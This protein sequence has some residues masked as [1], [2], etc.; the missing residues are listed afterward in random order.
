MSEGSRAEQDGENIHIQMDAVAKK[1]EDNEQKRSPQACVLDSE[2]EAY[3]SRNAKN[4]SGK[5][6]LEDKMSSHCLKMAFTEADIAAK[7][8]ELEQMRE[9]THKRQIE[10]LDAKIQ[11]MEEKKAEVERQGRQKLHE[12]FVQRQGLENE[13][14]QKLE[15]QEEDIMKFKQSQAD[16]IAGY[17]EKLAN[18][19]KNLVDE[20][21]G[22][23]HKQGLIAELV[24]LK[25]DEEHQH[26][27]DQETLKKLIEEEEASLQRMKQAH[28]ELK[29]K[30]KMES[31]LRMQAFNREKESLVNKIAKVKEGSENKTQ[32]FQAKH[33]N[34][35]ATRDQLQKDLDAE[36]NERDN[37]LKPLRKQKQDLS[38][39]ILSMQD[40]IRNARAKEEQ[41]TENII[42]QYEERYS[43]T[44]QDFDK[45]REEEIKRIFEKECNLKDEELELDKLRGDNEQKLKEIEREMNQKLKDMTSEI[46][47]QEENNRK[48]LQ[49][50][51]DKEKFRELEEQIHH[52]TC[53]LQN[54]EANQQAEE[55]LLK[56]WLEAV[57]DKERYLREELAAKVARYSNKISTLDN[58]LSAAK[59]Q[60]ENEQ[61]QHDALK[62]ETERKL[63]EKRD[64]F[65][66][67]TRDAA[68]HLNDLNNQIA[69][70]KRS[71]KIREDAAKDRGE[72]IERRI[73]EET[74]RL[75]K[76]KSDLEEQLGPLRERHNDLKQKVS[77]EKE[78]HQKNLEVLQKEQSKQNHDQED[79]LNR[80][81]AL[82]E[83]VRDQFKDERQQLQSA[84][85]E[86]LDSNDRLRE[87][88]EKEIFDLNMKLVQ[89]LQ[90]TSEQGIDATT[91][92]DLQNKVKELEEEYDRKSKSYN[93][94]LNRMSQEKDETNQ[95][96]D[97]EI[98]KMKEE[99][100]K[101]S[102]EYM[103]DGTKN[104][105]E[106]VEKLREMLENKTR[107][108]EKAKASTFSRTVNQVHLMDEVE[109][110][111]KHQKN[112]IGK[113]Q[114]KKKE[115]SDLMRQR[116]KEIED[117]SKRMMERDADAEKSN[118]EFDTGPLSSG[119]PK[120]RLDKL[121]S[122]RALIEA[123]MRERKKLLNE[124]A[125]LQQ[126]L[127]KNQDAAQLTA[128][129]NAGENIHIQLD[130]L[131]APRERENKKSINRCVLDEGT[132]DESAG[133]SE[134]EDEIKK[135]SKNISD[136]GSSE[137]TSSAAGSESERIKSGKPD[138][139]GGTSGAVASSGKSALPA[140]KKLY[141]TA[142][143]NS[144]VD[145]ED[146][147]S[148]DAMVNLASGKP[149]T[150]TTGGKESSSAGATL[151]TRCVA[152]MDYILELIA[153]KEN[154]LDELNL[155]D[156][157][158]EN[159]NAE[160]LKLELEA[161]RHQLPMDHEN[162]SCKIQSPAASSAGQN[163]SKMSKKE[164]RK[165]GKTK[166]SVR[167][168]DKNF[169]QTS[170]SKK[171]NPSPREDEENSNTPDVNSSPGPLQE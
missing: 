1:K 28:E 26:A 48:Q 49:Q 118:A 18:L 89:T 115:L 155:P 151:P 88:H 93:A 108:L 37:K 163:M 71:L 127:P 5:S 36:K 70:L 136:E 51:V 147:T 87:K 66:S 62:D 2:A 138:S 117:L 139:G 123:E 160:R 12:L 158:Q 101:L 96:C 125:R 143:G 33:A 10:E 64:E 128:G 159:E 170:E 132:G 46:E 80:L 104:P 79:E 19:Q 110:A 113:L 9:E 6:Q 149:G 43:K 13:L 162:M 76:L 112:L 23:V 47:E 129:S 35:L 137:T 152:P 148:K 126:E 31:E 72:T 59:Q 102:Q 97:D 116:R 91:T 106:R 45:E 92:R 17:K 42:N 55:A 131:V 73:G 38:D 94:T 145:N 164:K 57:T 4:F 153:E 34:L 150:A 167:F 25:N 68:S 109:E 154:E 156:L 52:K 41:K 40:K 63:Q 120:E 39:K 141:A 157:P 86:I 69:E 54:L 32:D 135:D 22:L 8:H 114:D 133:P 85:K 30:N 75:Q 65:E 122:L 130:E 27:K 165:S 78:K 146:D 77:E 81:Y 98:R 90:A 119:T 171:S 16:E 161:L 29:E 111:K 50:V 83:G 3:A 53:E 84:L 124:I 58:D 142:P 95:K 44:Q 82:L 74:R 61:R 7:R 60:A 14:R 105:S 20:R 56:V 11:E 166:N 24:A 67:Q 99:L 103:K 169:D 21:N 15:E 107:E 121:A 100:R 134:G 144:D 168:S 140:S